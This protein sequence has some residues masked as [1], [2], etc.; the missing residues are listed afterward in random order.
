MTMSF[1]L[2][3]DLSKTLSNNYPADLKTPEDLAWERSPFDWIRK[4]ASSTKGRIGR[5]FVA[6]LLQSAGFKS[7]RKG[8]SLEVNGK[9][10]QIKTSFKWGAGEFK[11]E[12]FR[13]NGYDFVFCLG[14]HPDSSYGW[15]IPKEELIVD[16]FMQ[17]REGLTAQHGG[18]KQAE[19]LEDLW[20]TVNPSNAQD[21][22]TRYGGTTDDVTAVLKKTL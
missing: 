19:D 9:I 5:D 6:A 12:Q 1:K 3:A 18:Q 17:D 15:L 10:V 22:L 11:F 2:L 13:D 14:L 4:K 16:G 20:L 21:W 8:V 7:Y